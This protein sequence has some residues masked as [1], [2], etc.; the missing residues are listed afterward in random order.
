MPT[1]S[2]IVTEDVKPP[3]VRSPKKFQLVHGSI[4]KLR[5]WEWD[6]AGNEPSLTKFIADYTSKLPENLPAE[7]LLDI[8]KW[9]IEGWETWYAAKKEAVLA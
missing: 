6:Q 7:V 1:I 8:T 9:A 5:L 2:T 4:I 3:W